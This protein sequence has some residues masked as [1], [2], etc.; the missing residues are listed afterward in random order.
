MRKGKKGGRAAAIM[1]DALSLF[2]VFTHS[3]SISSRRVVSPQ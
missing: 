1:A 3:A 2:V